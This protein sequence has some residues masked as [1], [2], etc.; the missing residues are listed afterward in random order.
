MKY[1]KLALGQTLRNVMG[2]AFEPLQISPL[3][4]YFEPLSVGM[5]VVI[6][7]YGLPSENLNT[8]SCRLFLSAT[9]TSPA[10]EWPACSRGLIDRFSLRNLGL[11]GSS[12]HMVK[13]F[14][15]SVA[16]PIS[17][18]SA[19]NS[20]PLPQTSNLDSKDSLY[21]VKPFSP[22]HALGV[23]RTAYLAYGY[24]YVYPDIYSPEIIRKR[25]LEGQQIS[26]VALG[27]SNEVVGHNAIWR[28]LSHVDAWEMGMAFVHPNYRR[29]GCL[30]TMTGVLIDK[31]TEMRIPSIFVQSVTGHVF[32]QEAAERL[33]FRTSGLRLCCGAPLDFKKLEV[34]FQIRQSF[35]LQVR[36][37]ESPSKRKLIA[38]RI[39]ADLLS[40]VYSNLEIP[41]TFSTPE[42]EMPDLP[43]GCG[44]LE[45]SRHDYYASADVKIL[46]VGLDTIVRLKTL[47]M[48][49]RR[50]KIE[51][52]SLWL[53][54]ADPAS[55]N[56]VDAALDMGFVFCGVLPDAS[57]KDWLIL[58]QVETVEIDF[59]QI[60]I[61]P[62]FGLRL[63]EHLKKNVSH[64]LSENAVCRVTLETSA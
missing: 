16:S 2:N 40:D 51:N 18:S 52:L 19:Q 4:I 14:D 55:V 29:L 42:E 20:E 35:L 57:T 27:Q 58:Q 50:R 60:H 26:V 9:E 11:E 17:S 7:H 44:W 47:L 33:R 53:S 36:L 54:L 8:Q 23:S 63:L 48:D 12:I 1:L 15:R 25:N 43:P 41:A 32:S 61:Y 5:E 10:S 64:E 24:S 37:I 39:Y 28:P 13:F 21:E 22:E 34:D 45:V 56:L 62:K 49:L 38:P 3:E 30:K 59:S 6:H 31:V 46:S